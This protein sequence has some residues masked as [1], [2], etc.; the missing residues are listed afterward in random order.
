MSRLLSSH[1]LLPTGQSDPH[2]WRRDSARAL[3]QQLPPADGTL[4]LICL[5]QGSLFLHSWQAG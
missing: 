2:V 3:K 4:L 1:G 5:R